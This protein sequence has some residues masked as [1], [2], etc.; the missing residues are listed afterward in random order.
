MELDGW[1]LT[2]IMGEG[3]PWGSYGGTHDGWLA[4]NGKALVVRRWL[5]GGC[6]SL[7]RLCDANDG[8]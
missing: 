4:L 8:L 6:H 1:N 2:A 7:Q 5:L 3:E